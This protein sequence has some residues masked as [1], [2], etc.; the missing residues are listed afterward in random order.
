MKTYLV[1]TPKL[2]QRYFRKR[3]WAFSSQ[4]DR[5][6]LT[7]DDGPIPEVTIWVLQELKKYNAKATFF[8]IGDNVRKHPKIFQQIVD[9]DHAF[10]NHTFHH[11]NGWNTSSEDFMN[12]VTQAEEIINSKLFRPPYGKL[13]GKQAALLRERG[14]SIIMWNVLSADF[15]IKISKEQCLQNVLKNIQPGS[16]IVFHDSLKAEEN[17]KYTLPKVLQFIAEKKWKCLPLKINDSAV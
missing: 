16:I 5:I 9:D 11:L 15:D 2:V 12:D 8:C 3:V 7:F 10:G 1:K 17:L 13:T 14:F 6:Y 4:A